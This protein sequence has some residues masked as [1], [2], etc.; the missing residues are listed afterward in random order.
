[1]Q[2]SGWPLTK[3]H[4]R[5]R[6]RQANAVFRTSSGPKEHSISK[7]EWRS[8]EA[9]QCSLQSGLPMKDSPSSAFPGDERPYREHDL[10]V[11]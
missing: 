7:R 9:S 11:S 3:H 8:L 6:S 2:S 5:G 4:S 1:M 10:S